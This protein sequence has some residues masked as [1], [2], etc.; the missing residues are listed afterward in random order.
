LFVLSVVDGVFFYLRQSAAIFAQARAAASSSWWQR[1]RRVRHNFGMPLAPDGG[2]GA[3]PW[4]N[5]VGPRAPA[6]Q[7]AAAQPWPSAAAEQPWPSAAAATPWS[8]ALPQKAGA[9]PVAQHAQGAPAS[10]PLAAAHS[11]AADPQP[12]APAA[13][14][15]SKWKKWG[16]YFVIWQVDTDDNSWTDYDSAWCELLE[17]HW[18]EPSESKQFTAR[19]RGTVDYMYDVD[20]FFQMNK[21]TGKRRLIRR[22]LIGPQEHEHSAARRSL[23]AQHNKANHSLEACY[24]R[25]DAGSNRSR[26]K[27]ATGSP[28][29]SR[30]RAD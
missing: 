11:R 16:E 17:K 19:P 30:S 29:R 13:A 24:R 26:S 25:R 18:R 3:S 15:P 21:E 1:R 2:D 4:A 23:V 10:Q 7:A 27:S 5:Y 8:P 14:A 28:S 22:V 9:A 20:E 6:A 12:A